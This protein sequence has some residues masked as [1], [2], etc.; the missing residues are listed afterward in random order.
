MFAVMQQVMR[1]TQDTMV[2]FVE[3]YDLSFTQMKLM[4]VLQSSHSPQPIG[5]IA[6]LVGASLPSAGRAVDGLVRNELVTRTEDPED[7]RVKRIELTPL[8]ASAMDTIQESRVKTL[9]GFLK[10][11]EGDQLADLSSAILPLKT[12]ACQATEELHETE[13]LEVSR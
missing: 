2:G 1:G 6:E 11:L 5:H 7:R 9:V 3:Q 10:E 8:G 12:V 4:F 13:D